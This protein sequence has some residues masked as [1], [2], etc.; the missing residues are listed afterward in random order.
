MT[1]LIVMPD[2]MNKLISDEIK[3]ETPEARE[4]RLQQ[5]VE[6]M[7]EAIRRRREKDVKNIPP[8]RESDRVSYFELDGEVIAVSHL[9]GEVVFDE[10]LVGGGIECLLGGNLTAQQFEAVLEDEG[11]SA[12]LEKWCEEEHC[13]RALIARVDPG[14]RSTA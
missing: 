10:E 7:L 9:D 5:C 13:T 11:F 2:E 4:A 6:K 12:F 1:N 8:N 14:T 3:N